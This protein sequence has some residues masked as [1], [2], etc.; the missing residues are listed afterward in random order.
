MAALL[1]FDCEFSHPAPGL[2]ALMQ[3][4]MV[5]VPWDPE[6]LSVVPN[7]APGLKLKLNFPVAARDT[8]TDWV[9]KNQSALLAECKA[10]SPDDYYTSRDKV[11]AFLK[12]AADMYGDPITP[13][14]WCLGSDMAYLLHLLGE[15][16]ELV[17]YSAVDLKAMVIPMMGALD[18]GDKETAAFLGVTPIAPDK[19]HDALEDAMYQLKLVLAAFKRVR[20]T[21]R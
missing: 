15:D 1:S 3:I 6:T 13:C 8:V 17:H 11:V 20:E 5:V 19:E 10:M 14:G 16:N 12:K 18:P 7:D 2:G 9:K 21:S 4:G